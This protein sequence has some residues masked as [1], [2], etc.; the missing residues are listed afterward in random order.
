MSVC[1]HSLHIFTKQLLATIGQK[2]SKL[3]TEI[4]LVRI[5]SNNQPQDF[6]YKSK[7]FMIHDLI[8]SLLPSFDDWRKFILNKGSVCHVSR[9]KSLHF[10]KENIDF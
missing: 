10:I 4:L 7:K 3:M 5:K 8:L 2:A 1:V 6:F 9:G